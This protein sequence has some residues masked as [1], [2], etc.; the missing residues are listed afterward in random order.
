MGAGRGGEGRLS[1]SVYTPSPW[2]ARFHAL[3]E[4]EALGAGAAGP[5]KT[6]CL[7]MHPVVTQLVVEH[8][9]ALNRDHPYH[10]RMGQSLGHALYLR[11]EAAMLGPDIVRAK[12]LY[13]IVDP[14]R[15]WYA[16]NS[17]AGSF[18]FS[19]GY[20]I[21]F[22]HCKDPDDWEKYQGWELTQ[23]LYDELTQFLETQYEQINTRLRTT[24]PVL[25]SM[26][27]IRAMSNP[28]MRKPAG[29]NFVMRDP[30]WVRRRFVDPAPAGN[31]L[32]YYDVRLDSGE[33]ARLGR[34]YL[35]ARLKDN[36]DKD[37]VRDYEIELRAAPPHMRAALLDGDWYV[38]ADSFY[39]WIWNPRLHIVEPYRIPRSWGI[40]RSMDWG[41]KQPGCV[42]YWALDPDDHLVMFKEITF[43]GKTDVEVAGILKE[44]EMRMG[45][46]GDKGSMLSGPADTQLWEQ[47]GGYAK[48]MAE[49]FSDKGIDWVKAGKH[50]PKHTRQSNAQ[51]L[52]KRLGDD[53]GKS[54][55]PA[56]SFFK[57]CDKTIQT[58]PAIPTDPQN[59]ECPLD[60]GEDHW[61]D[62]TLYA[63]EYTSRGPE[64]LRAF[65]EDD[66]D[67][68]G[69][70][71]IKM[72]GSFGYGGA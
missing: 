60:G 30:Q 10:I 16:D 57:H 46:W 1:S 61:H 41:Y 26:R 34:I 8:S 69:I 9:R 18:V 44:Y 25:R 64:F 29:S 42:G 47:R 40:F 58:L 55:I 27:V 56:I 12:H 50:G 65:S 20:R 6:L 31:T 7:L 24:D 39:G 11:R 52:L 5:G 66:D 36:P 21:T 49:T 48:S 13:E 19:C 70:P 54:G 35:P 67:W 71:E 22:G 38:T 51:R 72:T 28:M 68:D 59:T 33:T 15:K 2:Q 63:C 17:G 3:T 43:Q 45:F 62:M 4:R 23:I 37:F 32:L 14:K 53:G